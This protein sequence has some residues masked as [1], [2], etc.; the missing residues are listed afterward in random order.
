MRPYWVRLHSIAR[1]AIDGV[2]LSVLAIL[3]SAGSPVR[4]VASQL[5]AE[6]LGG[7]RE[8]VRLRDTSDA[9]FARGHRDRGL[10][11]T[12]TLAQRREV[13]SRREAK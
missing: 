6:S 3:L 8:V 13:E 1:L 11:G 2:G 10:G 12:G 5:A 7:S 4:I 9:D